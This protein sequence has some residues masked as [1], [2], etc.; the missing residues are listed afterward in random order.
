MNI[1][2]LLREINLIVYRIVYRGGN[3][4]K[5]MISFLWYRNNVLATCWQRIEKGAVISTLLW[6]NSHVANATCFRKQCRWAAEEILYENVDELR[7]KI[8]D[9]YYVSVRISGLCVPHAYL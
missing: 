3:V 7:R 4:T 9:G 5:P 1:R 8:S 6:W 2:E